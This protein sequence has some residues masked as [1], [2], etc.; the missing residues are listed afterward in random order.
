MIKKFLA[1][2]LVFMV[3]MNFLSPVSY[4]KTDAEKAA[5][6][7]AN[8]EFKLQKKRQKEL[9]KAAR[10]TNIL[11]VQAWA[12]AG[13]V[14]AQA[15]LSYA[16]ST[17]QRIQK[18]AKLS[19]EW[20][21]K[22]TA[23]NADLVENFIPLDYGTSKVKLP[24]LYGLAACR[25]QIG[26]YVEQNFYDAMRWA[27][28][29]ASENDTLSFAILGSAYYTGRGTRQDYKKAIEYLKKAGNEPLALSLLSDAYAK[30]HG[31][32]RDMA[33]S[34]FYSDYL[35]SVVKPKI[36]KQREKNSKK[37]EQRD[38]NSVTPTITR[39]PFNDEDEDKDEEDTEDEDEDKKA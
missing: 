7:E 25:S 26:K 9:A 30:G 17:G 1:I 12:N 31:V 8:K 23:N 13:D 34:Q 21:E 5:E 19:R 10:R 37:I 33:Q 11:K 18:D 35:Q 2:M 38:R 16:H 28:L 29:G 3:A 14:Q 6:K 36:D 20:K 15:I 22:A 39:D 32:D 27:E 24:R 4:A